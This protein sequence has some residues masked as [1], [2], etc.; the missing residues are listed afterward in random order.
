MA[1]RRR[2]RGPGG[3]TKPR[4]R[5]S[6]LAFHHERVN[7]APTGE[8]QIAAAFAHLRAV[9]YRHPRRAELLHIH[10][11]EIEATA[12]ALETGL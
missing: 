8:Q 11:T 1:G 10:A 6:A 3:S 2:A 7:S 5:D 9:I 12:R 4:K